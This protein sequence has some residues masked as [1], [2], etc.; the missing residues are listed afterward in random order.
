MRSTRL[1]P[2]VMLLDPIEWR[3]GWPRVGCPSFG[4]REVP[5]VHR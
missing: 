4:P 2:R 3:D 1:G 5:V